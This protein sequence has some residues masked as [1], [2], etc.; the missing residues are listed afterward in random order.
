MKNVVTWFE[1][2]V[3]DMSRAKQFYATVLQ[4]QFM[5]DEMDGFKMAIFDHEMGAASGMLVLGE[6]YRPSA[7]AAVIYLNGGEDLAEPLQRAIE[8]GGSVVVPK[9]PIDGGAKGYFAQFL[10]TEGNRVGLYSLP[11][12]G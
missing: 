9:T 12:P 1:L 10:D 4:T 7:D 5:D 11:Q 2:P 3:T 6:D 8:N